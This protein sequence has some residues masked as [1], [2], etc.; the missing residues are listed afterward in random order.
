MRTWVRSLASLSGLRIPH[1]C[2]SGVGRQL[3]LQFDLS[4]GASIC[5]GCSPKKTKDKRK[6]KERELIF[7]HTT[8]T[9]MLCSILWFS[10]W[11]SIFSFK[12]MLTT[13]QEGG[14]N[15][16]SAV[17][18]QHKCI[19]ISAILTLWNFSRSCFYSLLLVKIPRCY[20]CQRE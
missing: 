6:K 13:I 3:Q 10:Y 20:I 18:E 14:H 8:G 17:T 1:C 4:L 12:K 15:V 19:I 2:G 16:I 11:Y 5:H 9:K 7:M